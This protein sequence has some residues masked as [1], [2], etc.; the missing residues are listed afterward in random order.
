MDPAIK[1]PTPT[2]TGKTAVADYLGHGPQATTA[3]RG[4]Q[5][6]GAGL[7]ITSNA[8]ATG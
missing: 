6:A 4:E 2:L 8:G 7:G 3:S 1:R 5:A